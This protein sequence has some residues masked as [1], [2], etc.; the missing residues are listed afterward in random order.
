MSWAKQYNILNEPNVLSDTDINLV[1]TLFLKKVFAKDFA[2]EFNI[3]CLLNPTRAGVVL[4]K[5]FQDARARFLSLTEQ[6]EDKTY[7][8]LPDYVLSFEEF[9][10]KVPGWDN[11]ETSYVCFRDDPNMKGCLMQRMST[12]VLSYMHAPI[13][14]QHYLVCRTNS[15]KKRVGMLDA[16]SYMRNNFTTEQ[17]ERQVFANEGG[18][19]ISFLRD[20]LDPETQISSGSIDLIKFDETL[21][22]YGP[23]L[24]SQFEVY[25]DFLRMNKFSYDNPVRGNKQ[26]EHAMLIVG[27]RMDGDTLKFLLQNWWADKQFVEVSYYYLRQCSRPG[28][29]SFVNTPQKEIPSVFETKV[30]VL[31]ESVD[32][33]DVGPMDGHETKRL[34]R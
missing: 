20:I 24:V 8:Y 12:S 33:E 31:A 21:R 9:N 4:M 11:P 1:E 3:K 27:M 34:K 32:F 6:E 17:L 2:M 30:C 23:L 25:E 7:D 29:I 28:V 18:A 22:Q 26:G 14:L 19:S 16:I 15:Q 10:K 13:V 5:K